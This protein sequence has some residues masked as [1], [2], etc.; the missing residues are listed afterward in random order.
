[1]GF[2]RK[3][4]LPLF[5]P[6][7]FIFFLPLLRYKILS[8]EKTIERIIQNKC[9][10]IR[11]GD[12]ELDIMLGGRGPNFQNATI[13]LRRR[14]INIARSDSNNV[15]ICIPGILSW[16]AIAHQLNQP[17]LSFWR[18]FVVLR[19]FSIRT[20]F[21]A[22]RE[23]GDA[24]IS[25]PYMDF[26][27]LEKKKCKLFFE[28]TRQIWDNRE[29]LLVEG[30]LTRFGVGN[31]LLQNAA[32]V[33]RIL[34]PPKDA[35]DKYSK[36]YSAIL[37]HHKGELI[38]IAGGPIAK[39]LV[40]DLSCLNI[41]AVDIGHLDIEYEWFLR[42]ANRKVP[43]PGKYTNE[44]TTAYVDSVGGE[45]FKKYLSEIICQIQ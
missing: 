15:V 26:T 21:S 34:I 39:V 20:F 4:L 22:D 23:Y 2:A 10:V 24:F 27:S 30:A 6:L 42:G 9:S 3:Y 1:M 37:K 18:G 41:Q 32:S 25:R 7:L 13:E 36:I 17:A 33:S 38:L 45:K 44:A 14:L 28:K 12:G 19:F 11:F 29:V 43:I 35:F 40:S 16:N 31:D 8:R 5:V